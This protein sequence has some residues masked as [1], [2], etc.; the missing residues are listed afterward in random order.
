MAVN[1]PI[2]PVV[3][4]GGSGSR[5]WPLSRATYPKQLIALTGERSLLQ[6]TLARLDGLAPPLV[7]CNQEHR[8]LVAEQL[9][10]MTVAAREIVLEPVGRNTAPAACIAALLL[11]AEDPGALMMLLPSDHTIAD[12]EA[13]RRGGAL[14]AQA[15]QEGW[16]V[17]FG[18]TPT[19]P[20]TGYGYIR[21][22]GD[23]A[24]VQGCFKVGQFV[25]KPDPETAKGYLASGEFSWNSGIFVFSAGALLEELERLQ[26]D[27]VRACREALARATRDLDFLRLDAG[28]FEAAPA[29]SLDY[30]VMEKTDRAAVIPLDMGWSDLGSWDAL[31]RASAPDADGNAVLGDVLLADTQGSYLRSEGRL[32]AV[33]GLEDML[34]VETAD[35]VLV[36]PR[37]RAQDVGLLAERLARAGRSEQAH[38]RRV[39]RPWGS[40]E[41]VDS[42]SGF[43]VKRLI[44]NPGASISLQRH[45]HRSEHWVVVRGA[46]EVTRDDEVFTLEPNQSTYV[47]AGAR[48][49]LHN[50][51]DEPLHIVEVQCGSNLDEDDIE[52]LEDIYGRS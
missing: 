23:P 40:Y 11:G 7:I 25:E 17:T 32:L 22:T 18:V 2:H 8:F 13:F 37:G 38:P 9:H 48:H 27:I 34:V 15:A 44:V 39:Y 46:A 33:A 3:L 14:A 47:A 24:A 12:V 19:S 29:I 30:A 35:A 50:P 41:P 20:E 49:R 4:S 45:R 51:G 42:G 43:Q 5:L 36:C 26:P 52:R 31:W 16:F 21:R 6:E 10:E 1:Q 28:A